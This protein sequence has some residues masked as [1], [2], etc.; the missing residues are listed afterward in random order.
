MSTIDQ[1]LSELDGEVWDSMR[2]VLT[3][4][5]GDNAGE[6]LSDAL[7]GFKE[8]EQ[9]RNDFLESLTASIKEAIAPEA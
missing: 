9:E 5:R 3:I 1:Q 2:D 6:D 8:A 4:P 7:N